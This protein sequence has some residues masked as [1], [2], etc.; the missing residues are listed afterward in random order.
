M[1]AARRYPERTTLVDAGRHAFDLFADTG[2]CP[3]CTVKGDDAHEDFCAFF[4]EPQ[5][6]VVD[7]SGGVR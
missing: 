5:P 2:V 3:F 7:V 1:S 6:A 4:E